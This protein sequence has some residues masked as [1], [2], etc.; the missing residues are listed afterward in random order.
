MDDIETSP[1]VGAAVFAAAATDVLEFKAR[2]VVRAAAT[3]SLTEAEFVRR[4]RG[5]GCAAWSTAHDLAGNAEHYLIEPAAGEHLAFSDSELGVG[6]SLGELRTLWHVSAMQSRL[7]QAE[8]EGT[9][10]GSEFDRD[11]VVLSNATTWKH[12]AADTIRFTTCLAGLD[13]EAIDDHRWAA[14]RLAG[15]YAM[16]ALKFDSTHN[17]SFIATMADYLCAV[18]LPQAADSASPALTDLRLTNTAYGIA[19]WRHRGP[20][21]SAPAL[22]LLVPM[23]AGASVVAT[24]CHRRG[25]TALAGELGRAVKC[26]AASLARL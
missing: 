7:A 3:A 13:D 8:W 24:A 18:A 6:L 14:G 22:Q 16:W 9:R 20:S 15:V 19:Q 21:T 2:R 25:E 5:F 17:G 10:T 11:R 4:I 12:I 26:L 23:A 1:T